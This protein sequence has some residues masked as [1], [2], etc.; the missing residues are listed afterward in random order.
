[1]DRKPA[2]L[3]FIHLPF[4]PSIHPYVL[5]ILLYFTLIHNQRSFSPFSSICSSVYPS[6]SSPHYS[7][8]H[9]SSRPVIYL[10]A[11]FAAQF[12]SIHPCLKSCLL[13]PL[14]VSPITHASGHSFIH[15]PHISAPPGQVSLVPETKGYIWCFEASLVPMP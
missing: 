11:H 5:Y 8:I 15:H 3:L 13:L 12:P 2:V 1:M 6:L 4:H 9:L 7:P 10:S 14:S